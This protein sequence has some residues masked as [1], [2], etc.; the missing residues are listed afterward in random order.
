MLKHCVKNVAKGGK[1][2]GKVRDLYAQSTAG[3]KYLT[4]QVFFRHS[5]YK[6][7]KQAGS[8]YKQSDLRA[9]SQLSIN[10][11]PFSTIPMTNTNLIKD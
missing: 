5:F 3:P 7:Y 4:S 1:S 11:Y 9:F 10:L 8:C 2:F 6:F